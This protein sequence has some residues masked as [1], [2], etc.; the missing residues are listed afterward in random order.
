MIFGGFLIRRG[1]VSITR[2]AVYIAPERLVC[3]VV[4]PRLKKLERK[5]GISKSDGVQFAR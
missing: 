3:P 1:S 2:G 4:F 5:P